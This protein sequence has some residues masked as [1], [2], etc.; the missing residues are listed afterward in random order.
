MINHPTRS[1][2]SRH[3]VEFDANS[4]TVTAEY[5]SFTKSG[6]LSV[7]LDGIELA[8]IEWEDYKPEYFTDAGLEARARA[9]IAGA[10]EFEADPAAD[11]FPPVVALARQA[12]GV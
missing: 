2:T 7:W 9:V 12:N 11:E 8:V 10:V 6:R 3:E 1:K 4:V 5:I